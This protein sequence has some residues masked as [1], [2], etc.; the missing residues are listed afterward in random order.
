[1]RYF[2]AT[3]AVLLGLLGAA[4]AQA[5]NVP[6]NASEGGDL[7]GSLPNIATP[8]RAAVTAPSAAARTSL[9]D[10]YAAIPLGERI[11]IQSDLA[12]ASYYSGPVNG[13]FSDQFVNAVRTFQTK[14]K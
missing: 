8:P 14:N 4:F 2:G 10:S 11:A 1:M 5:S 9:K 12:W 6:G 3:F 7:T 13:E